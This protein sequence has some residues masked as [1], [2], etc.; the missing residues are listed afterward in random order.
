[1]NNKLVGS[2]LLAAVALV[3]GF[4]GTKY[5][6][7][8]DPV[9]IWTICNGATKGVKQGD[10]ATPKE[11][12]DRLIVELL[13]HA[14]PLERIP[15]KL[16]DHVIVAWADFCYNVGVGACSNSTGYKMLERGDI[17]G[18]CA[19]LLRWRYTAGVDCFLDTNAKVCGGIKKRRQLEY[20]LCAGQITIAEAVEGLR[21]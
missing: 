17:N 16:P 11:C 2:T 20:K 3:A 12:Q 14:K 8:Q 19:Q 7:Y 9:G 18:A 4:E 10:T 13:E 15:H 21:N 5:V 1:M 6:A